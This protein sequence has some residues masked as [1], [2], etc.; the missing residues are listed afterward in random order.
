MVTHCYVKFGLASCSGFCQ[1]RAYGSDRQRGAA[2]RTLPGDYTV[3]MG[4]K[5]ISRICVLNL[6]ILILAAF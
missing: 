6:Q 2:V 5:V 4:N 3:I 1:Y